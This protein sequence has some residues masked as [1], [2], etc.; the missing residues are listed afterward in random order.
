MI[1]LVLDGLHLILQIELGNA[2]HISL[3]EHRRKGQMHDFL[4]RWTMIE[5]IYLQFLLVVLIGPRTWN[6]CLIVVVIRRLIF[7]DEIF[8]LDVYSLS[9]VGLLPCRIN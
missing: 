9:I 5:D 4:L 2:W 3:C 8:L 7:S 6:V 1:R